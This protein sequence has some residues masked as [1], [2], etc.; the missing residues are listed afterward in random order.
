MDFYA[1]LHDWYRVNSVRPSTEEYVVYSMV[2][3]PLAIGVYHVG[4][5]PKWMIPAWIFPDAIWMVYWT[6]SMF[7]IDGGSAISTRLGYGSD[8]IQGFRILHGISKHW[9]MVGGEGGLHGKDF[10]KWEDKV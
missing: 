1:I 9:D 7:K 6:S 2:Q 8:E 3:V 5:Q 4:N 10:N